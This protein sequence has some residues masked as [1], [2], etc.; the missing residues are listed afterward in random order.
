MLFLSLSTLTLRLIK[1]GIRWVRNKDDKFGSFLAGIGAGLVGIKTLNKKYWYIL[2]MFMASRVAAAIHQI[3]IQK[4]VLKEENVNLH[5]YLLFTFAHIVHSYGYFIEPDILRPDMYN[6]Y[7]KMSVLT[8][9]E[10]K[11]HLSSLEYTHR[12]LK[13]EGK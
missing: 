6:L 13:E 7:E 4:K 1:C 5:Y 9:P 2:L 11:W 12:T 3:L 8:T 10:K